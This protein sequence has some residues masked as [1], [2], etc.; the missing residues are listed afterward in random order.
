MSKKQNIQQETEQQRIIFLNAAR[1]AANPLNA[2][3]IVN[4]YFGI[5][6][7]RHLTISDIIDKVSTLRKM[8]GSLNAEPDQI[9]LEAEHLKKYF[10]F[11]SLSDVDHAFNMYMTSSLENLTVPHTVHFTCLFLTQVLSSYNRYRTRLIGELNKLAQQELMRMSSTP[12]KRISDI[13]GIITEC[14]NHYKNGWQESFYNQMVFDFIRK[15]GRLKIT[16]DL[17]KKSREYAEERYNKDKKP[18][19]KF[20]EI[21]ARRPGEVINKPYAQ[22]FEKSI[23]IRKYGVDYC[24]KYFFDK[25]EMKK[26]IGDITVNDLKKISD[27]DKKKKSNDLQKDKKNAD[28]VKDDN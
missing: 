12:E 18:E 10:N 24:L 25:N 13:K 28:S 8:M 17:I 7:L 4:N 26:V 23:A 15:T 5:E 19:E 16:N 3:I 27:F 14:L 22:Q 21:S 11:L 1:F 9:K 2:S 6:K 20:T